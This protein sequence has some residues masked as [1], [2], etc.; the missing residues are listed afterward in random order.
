MPAQATKERRLELRLTA[1]QRKNLEEAAAM[2]GLS[3]SSY[4]LNSSLLKAQQDLAAN[5]GMLIGH[6]D[7]AKIM[8][9]LAHPPAPNARLRKAAKAYLAHA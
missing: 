8:Q 1:D 7:Q 9:A 2:Q 4:L 3:I 6:E 5:R